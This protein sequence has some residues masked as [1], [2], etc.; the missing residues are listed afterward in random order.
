METIKFLAQLPVVV[1][2]FLDSEEQS[3]VP[4]L[5]TGDGVEFLHR[6]GERVD[7]FF[8]QRV[9]EGLWIGDFLLSWLL[10]FL[11]SMVTN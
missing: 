8:L 1:H 11:V 2:G 7:I 9:G 3:G 10:F 5:E 6:L 4:L